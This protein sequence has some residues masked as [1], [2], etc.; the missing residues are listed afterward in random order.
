MCNHECDVNDPFNYRPDMSHYLDCPVWV[1]LLHYQH[2]T[3]KDILD[4]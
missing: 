1:K 4:V 3:V 2:D